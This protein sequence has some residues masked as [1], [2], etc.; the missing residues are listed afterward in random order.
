MLAAFPKNRFSPESS[1]VPEA[2]ARSAP[3]RTSLRDDATYS[4]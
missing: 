2:A 4:G 1:N 3:R